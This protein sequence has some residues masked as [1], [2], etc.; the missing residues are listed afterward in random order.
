MKIWIVETGCAT[1]TTSRVEAVFDHDPTKE[2]VFAIENI[3][4]YGPWSEP[5][6]LGPRGME[7]R[8]FR[9]Y[10]YYWISVRPYAVIQ[11]EASP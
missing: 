5:F 9:G 11:E 2:E 3:D 1:K 4:I 8:E 7:G 10:C 6:D